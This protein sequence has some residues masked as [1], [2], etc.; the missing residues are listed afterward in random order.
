MVYILTSTTLLPILSVVLDL[1]A[2]PSLGQQRK[3]LELKQTAV[4]SPTYIIKEFISYLDAVSLL[5]KRYTKL[6]GCTPKFGVHAI[7]TEC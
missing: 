1:Q 7:R 3:S 5:E 4:G 6:M 2:T